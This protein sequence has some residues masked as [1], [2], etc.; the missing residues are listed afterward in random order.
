MYKR[1]FCKVILF[2]RIFIGSNV[3]DAGTR[4]S[5][6]QYWFIKI[7]FLNDDRYNNKYVIIIHVV[8]L[9]SSYL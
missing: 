8:I 5:D 6:S 1:K 7:R 4:L 2:S 3:I 9:N